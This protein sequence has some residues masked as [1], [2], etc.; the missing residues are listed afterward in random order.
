MYERNRGIMEKKMI[1]VREEEMER[2]LVYKNEQEAYLL[3]PSELFYSMDITIDNIPEDFRDLEIKC[4]RELD[5]NERVLGTHGMQDRIT[6][7]EKA[8]IVYER[9]KLIP[10]IEEATETEPM[11]K[12][13]STVQCTLLDTAE[14]IELF[15]DFYR[16][17]Q[18]THPLAGDYEFTSMKE[19]KEW[20]KSAY[21]NDLLSVG[22]VI[23]PSVIA[24]GTTTSKE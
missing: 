14:C 23:D 7:L 2:R 22:R 9:D 18:L 20:V 13:D 19:A 5:N 1:K 4:Q 6:N 11:A 12:T 3:L 21:K 16:L 24:S 17:Y 8:V 10:R 15:H